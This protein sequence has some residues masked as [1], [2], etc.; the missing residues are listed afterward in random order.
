MPPHNPGSIATPGLGSFIS[1]F[2]HRYWGNLMLISF[3]GGTEMYHFPPFAS[4]D[5][6]FIARWPAITPA[7]LPHS[8]ISGSKPA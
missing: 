1:L 5:Y 2:A 7:G 6:G 8:E 4:C 3:P